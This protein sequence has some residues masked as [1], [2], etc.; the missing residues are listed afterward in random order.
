[1]KSLFQINVLALVL[2]LAVSCAHTPD[3]LAANQPAVPLSSLE[4]NKLYIL[5]ANEIKSINATHLKECNC[6]KAFHRNL[7]LPPD[8]TARY[9]F[10]DFVGT[11]AS[12][13]ARNRSVSVLALGSGFLLNELTAI[14]NILAR[15]I[16]A[17]IYLSDWAYIF[18][19]DKDFEEKALRFGKN[20]ETIPE[21]WENFYFWEMATDPKREKDF[22]PFFKRHHQAIDEFKAIIKKLDQA[23]GTSSTVHVIKQ[24][25]NAKAQ[26]PELDLIISIDSFMDLPGM[27]SQLHY[28][29]QPASQPVRYVTINKI[30]PHGA[31]WGSGDKNIHEIHSRKPVTIEAYDISCLGKSGSYHRLESMVVESSESQINNG[32]NFSVEPDDKDS[33]QSPFDMSQ[34]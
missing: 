5:I 27:I 1:M 32:I 15:G 7:F 4:K 14:A 33:T 29:W 19:E 25:M 10:D 17:T 8:G 12:K 20:L 21:A 30:K 13:L 16:D 23:F 24:A 11:E 18:Y 2:L 34:K 6:M 22:L 9:L 28:R 26:L 3:R 31:F